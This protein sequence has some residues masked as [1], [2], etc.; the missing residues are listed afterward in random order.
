MTSEIF[1]QWILRWDLKL[2]KNQQKALLIIDNC[3]AH[4]IT[5]NLTNIEI[6][7]LPSNSTA[8]TQPLDQ[9]IIKA[10]KSRFSKK[11]LCY[12]IEQVENGINV[13]TA[14][15]TLTVKDA[16]IFTKY[17][18]DEISESTI[19]NCFKKAK[20]TTNLNDSEIITENPEI[21]IY[22]TFV[23]RSGI[24]DPMCKDEFL[25]IEYTENDVLLDSYA[26]NDIIP[27]NDK[28]LL[29]CSSS[30]E[31]QQPSVEKVSKT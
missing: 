29:E 25:S 14:F 17:A 8:C 26:D 7:F 13:F 21:D 30:E 20:W 22:D 18:W 9:G 24:V 15:K 12:V 10:F 19:C 16:L 1:N 28:N 11:K 3:P 4:K 27:P 23:S 6:I 2:Q 5:I 31:I